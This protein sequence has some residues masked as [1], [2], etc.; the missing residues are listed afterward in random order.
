MTVE[1]GFE[2]LEEREIPEI[3]SRARLYRHA[4]T[5]AQLLSLVNQDENKVFGITFRTPPQDSTGVAHIMEHAVLCGS[6]KY[7]V[8]E[9]FVELLK[10]SLNTFL[11]AMTFPDKTCYPVASQN[12]QDFYNLIDVYLDAV[13]YPLIPPHTLQQE[14]WHFE[15]ESLDAPLA[16]KGVVFNEMK[17]FYSNPD[18]LLGDRARG[19][20]FP[21]TPYAVD[22][23]G[24]PRH[25]P[26][27]TYPQFKSFHDQF[28]HPSN[29]RIFF[30]GDDDP[31][32]RLRLMEAYL[33]QFKAIEVDS[34]IPLQ[35]RFDQP[36]RLVERFDP[37]DDPNNDKGRLVVNWL[38]AETGDP[39]LL[40][41][42]SI[43]EHILL[44]TPAS[45]LRKALIDSGLG[46]DLAG[47]GLDADLR[48]ACFS[49]GLKGLSVQADHSLAQ[50]GVVESLILDTLRSL[51]VDGIDPEMVAASMNTVEFQLRE[52]NTGAYPRGLLLM[53]RALGTWLYDQDPFALLA[54]EAPLSAIK[55]RLAA[56]ERYFEGLIRAYLID[57][58]HR[59]TLTLQPQPGL[60]QVEDAAEKERLALAR[61]RLTAG[62]LERIIADTGRLKLLQETP[63]TLEAL[64]TIP[65]LKLEDLE[66]QNK[67]IPLQV[68]EHQGCRVLYHD[69]S[70]NGIVYLDLG[71]DLHALPQELLPFVPLFGQALLEMGT[72]SEDFVRL[73]Q[74]IG[75]TTGGIWPVTYT[76][77]VRGQD[78]STAWLF[79]RGK[80]TLPQA[81]ELLAVLRDVLL[82][83][84]LD[85][86][87]RFRQ[88]VLE[89][90][91]GKESMLVP[92]GH[93]VVNTRLRA[94][95]DEAAWVEEQMHGVDSLFF[96]REL[97]QAMEKDWP[98]VLAKLEAIRQVL[99]NRGS[100]LC[101]VTLDGAHWATFR[102]QLEG[103]LAQLP[104]AG[105]TPVAWQPTLAT[106]FEGL[107]IPAQVNY[108]GKG[109]N[110]Y[111]LGY[112]AHGSVDVIT[113]YLRTTWLWERVRVQGGAYGGFCLFNRRS[114]V[115][116]YLSYRDPNLLSTLA[117]YDAAARFLSE[118][119]LD[120][121]EL[122]KSIIGAIGEM[123]AY[124]LPD[125]KGYTSLTRYLAGDTDQDRQ[126]WR[127]QILGT[128]RSDFHAFGETLAG[129]AEKG[130]VVVLGSLEAIERANA[131]RGD[132]WLDVKKIL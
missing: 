64:A 40:L 10:G 66:R 56:G 100:M 106:R 121:A 84:R 2:L 93:R 122:T 57:N 53:L 82:T 116:T 117:N 95:F 44:G 51:A 23:G 119:D 68:S 113:N 46:E 132:G 73:S 50:G 125:A 62:D 118:L 69:L 77:K 80:A 39:E 21:D 78:R 12:L 38:L 11:N 130:L 29:A 99:V 60:S 102:P 24:D 61:S 16:Y 35:P 96:V 58:P 32:E 126:R 89:D 105:F 101:N 1:H 6:R 13:F 5:R 19:S 86:P 85:N 97:A 81:S 4:G 74:R 47:A 28:Y 63:D 90:K 75:R 104:A 65:S 3:N 103:F 87:E 79:L 20:L 120:P 18:D 22:A 127:E 98:S 17:G 91:A 129:L 25:I 43:L 33:S 114:G 37:G 110:L 15:L 92:A 31:A 54:F 123:D 107:A 9:P 26:E 112:T 45:P 124:Q 48:Q 128:T 42:L 55:D 72:E 52:N 34:S 111:E 27:L 30:Y 41:G 109:A 8:K 115:F 108:V 94:L 67:L 71:L 7:P 36:Q 88:M 83:V 49:T 14:G 59:T 131:E 76:S 70:T